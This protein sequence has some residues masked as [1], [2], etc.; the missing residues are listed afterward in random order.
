[1]TYYFTSEVPDLK[2]VE[3]GKTK[4]TENRM[5]AAFCLADPLED[6]YHWFP[7]DFGSDE[8]VQYHELFEGAFKE[9]CEGKK[10][11]IYTVEA[12]AEDLVSSKEIVSVFHSEKELSVTDCAAIDDLY[13]W[14]MAE[15]DMGRFRLYTF[16]QHTRQELL[17]WDNSI[18]RYLAKKGM[19]DDEENPYAKFVKEK[20]PK[21]WEKYRKLCGR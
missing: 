5:I 7:C 8:T 2:T 9:A 17:I 15:E 14:L 12:E 20:L 10:G 1:M 4:L 19:I 13:E 6:P 11:F 16:D 3:P 18:L 21:T